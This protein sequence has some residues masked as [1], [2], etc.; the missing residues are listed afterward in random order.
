[1]VGSSVNF[2]PGMVN[3]PDFPPLPQPRPPAPPVAAPPPRPVTPLV[4]VGTHVETNWE[5]YKSGLVTPPRTNSAP[6]RPNVETAS[7]RTA[8]AVTNGVAVTNAMGV[9]EKPAGNNGLF[10][11]VTGIVIGAI[12]LIIWFVSRP[13]SGGSLISD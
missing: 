1:Y 5:A 8:P 3:L 2:P 9:A 7:P 10:A 12:A 11:L 6:A 13:R 4:I